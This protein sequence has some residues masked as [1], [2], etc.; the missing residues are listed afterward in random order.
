MS[1]I[2]PNTED[3]AIAPGLTTPPSYDPANAP[4]G[5]LAR[6]FSEACG[7]KLRPQV[8]NAIISQIA[9]AIDNAGV[10]Y[11]PSNGHIDL[12]ESMQYYLQKNLGAYALAA[13]GPQDFTAVGAP[14]FQ[15][16]TRGQILWLEIPPAILSA[17]NARLNVDGLG[18][19]NIVR[20]DGSAT[21]QGDLPAGSV[22]GL[23][24]RNNQWQLVTGG[25]DFMAVARARL[26]F[27]PH[28]DTPGNIMGVASPGAGSVVVPPGVPFYHRSV[29]AD[30]TDNYTLGQ[31]TFATAVSKTYH[32]RWRR[33]TGFA[34]L[35][36]ADVAYNPTALAET[37]V[38]FDSTFDDMLVAKV[39][40]NPANVATVTNL[41]N[42]FRYTTLVSR[43]GIVGENGNTTSYPM[44][45][46]RVPEVSLQA[47]VAPGAGR[48]TDPQ[49]RVASFDR[50]QVSI[51][52]WGW[53]DPPTDYSTFGYT[54]K[55]TMPGGG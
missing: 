16:Y 55:I 45:F 28:I 47:I 51:Y 26:P 11:D 38:K 31:R 44:N 23:A 2:F 4:I 17:A 7:V 9:A 21:V 35:D 19:A 33:T 46:S 52:T 32:L 22:V 6:Y 48:D 42:T 12:S 8:L 27:Y 25:T 13:G 34:L 5:T 53:Q 36:L 41:R 3:G 54:Y 39:V 14:T 50:Y 40:T 30:S 49:L 29:F 15:A 20:L 1:G 18:F 37:D 24:Y 10:R 43:N